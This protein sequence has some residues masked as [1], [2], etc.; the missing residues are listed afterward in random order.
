MGDEHGLCAPQMRVRRHQRLGGRLPLIGERGNQLYETVLQQRYPT[1]QV[2][3]Q[4]ERHLLVA[5]A[6]GMKPSPCVTNPLGQLSLD[7]AMN[8]LVGAGDED[9]KSTRLNS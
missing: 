3:P 6:S 5:R 4:I 2:E 9:R 8:V 1:T 7:E